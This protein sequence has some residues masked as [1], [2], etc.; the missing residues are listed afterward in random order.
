[1]ILTACK[2]FN[3]NSTAKIVSIYEVGQSPLY[4]TDEITTY[5]NDF[6]VITTILYH[7]PDKLDNKH[8]CD[9]FVD[10]SDTSARR[11]FD[12]DRIFF[13]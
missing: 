11:V 9:V 4:L 12:P 3:K 8:W 1:M 13:K 6:G 7:E 10:H 5:D 2:G